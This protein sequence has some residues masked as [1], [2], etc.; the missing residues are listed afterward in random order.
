MSPGVVYFYITT[1]D[2]GSVDGGSWAIPPALYS[3]SNITSFTVAVDDPTAGK[4]NAVYTFT[5][6]PK[7]RVCAGAYI[8][9]SLP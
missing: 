3:R 7:N 9:V 8:D 6:L 2:G 4:T 1:V 5:V